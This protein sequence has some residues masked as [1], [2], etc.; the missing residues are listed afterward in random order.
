MYVSCLFNLGTTGDCTS[1]FSLIFVFQSQAT[2]ICIRAINGSVV[3]QCSG[4]ERVYLSYQI[5][6]HTAHEL[7]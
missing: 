3:G 7:P 2:Y 1:I 6:A 4:P 5:R